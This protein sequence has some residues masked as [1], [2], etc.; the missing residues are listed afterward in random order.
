MLW[1]GM[2]SSMKVS[3]M[4]RNQTIEGID[5]TGNDRPN[6]DQGADRRDADAKFHEQ[7]AKQAESKAREAEARAREAAANKKAGQ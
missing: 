2:F 7:A 3:S 6:P 5:M 4:Q 1:L